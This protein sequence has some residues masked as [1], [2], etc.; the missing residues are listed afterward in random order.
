MDGLVKN[1]NDQHGKG[2]TGISEQQADISFFGE[3]Q[4]RETLSKFKD[5]GRY[6][7]NDWENVSLYMDKA[8]TRIE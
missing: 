8:I 4:Y 7:G 2:I 5:S 3:G 1:F 6:G